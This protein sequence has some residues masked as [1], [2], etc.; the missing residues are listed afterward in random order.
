MI[1]VLES[2]T[3]LFF[4][5][6]EACNFTTFASPALGVPRFP[7]LLSGTMNF[8]GARLLSS[9][10]EQLYVSDDFLN[11]KPLLEILAQPGQYL[12]T[13][14]KFSSQSDRYRYL[15]PYGSVPLQD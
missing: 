4:D 11:G 5:S 2:R 6:I 10:G 7:G 13:E 14:I 15:F 8:L 12:T 1:G 3:S 9:T